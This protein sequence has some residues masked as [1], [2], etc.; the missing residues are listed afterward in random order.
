[1]N[2]KEKYVAEKDK[3]RYLCFAEDGFEA[4]V[5]FALE[6][7]VNILW[8]HGVDEEVKKMMIRNMLIEIKG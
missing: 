2:F 4:G 3:N 6:E 5:E 7:V 8:Q 1:M